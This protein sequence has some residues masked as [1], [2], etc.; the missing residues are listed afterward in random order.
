MGD[1]NV[2]IDKLDRIRIEVRAKQRLLAKKQQEMSKLATQVGAGRSPG[3]TTSLEKARQVLL[4]EISH[5][6]KAIRS[7]AEEYA[8]LRDRLE[9]VIAIKGS[10]SVSP[11][12]H[13][14]PILALSPPEPV[15]LSAFRTPSVLSAATKRAG[16]KDTEPVDLATDETQRSKI[17]RSVENPEIYPTVFNAQAAKYFQVSPR[18]IYRWVEDGKLKRGARRGTVTTES[19]RGWKKVR[20]RRRRGGK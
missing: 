16:E 6:V 3:N 8:G 15:L 2:L 10:G 20:A 19:M 18:Q 9:R 5:L 1:P 13:L 14:G 12:L 7:A 17:T 11:P 4:Q